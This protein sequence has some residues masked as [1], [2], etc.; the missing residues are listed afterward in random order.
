MTPVKNVARVFEYLSLQTDGKPIEKT[1]LNK[2]LYFAQG[3]AMH[4]LGHELFEN[5]IDAWDHG[6]VVAVVYSGFDK[7]VEKAERMGISDITIPP[8]ELDVI[9]D[10]WDQYCG[11]TAKELVDKTHESGSPWSDTYRPNEKNLHIPVELIGKYFALPE[12]SLK[13]GTDAFG[14][15]PTVHCL[16]AEEYDPEEDA[17]WEALLNEA[18]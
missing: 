16:P 15:L 4:E 17:I 1:R 12:N 8:D 3:H 5:S 11:Y 14:S 18:S 6:P 7:I 13:R 2:L 10:V 9:I